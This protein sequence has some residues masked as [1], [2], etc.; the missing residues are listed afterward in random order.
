VVPIELIF[1]S[2]IIGQATGFFYL[3]ELDGRPQIA[4]VTNWHVLS[5][6][7]ADNPCLTLHKKGATPDS[8]RI[9]TI[10]KSSDLTRG[11]MTV[12]HYDFPMYEDD[13]RARWLQHPLK[14]D[15]DIALAFVNDNVSGAKIEPVNVVADA[16]DMKIEVGNDVYILGYPLGYR[17]FAHTPIWKRGTI[18]SEPNYDIEG[19]DAGKRVL[20]DATTRSAMSGS[21]V[22]MRQ[23]TH[24]LSAEGSIVQK[25]NATRFIGV[26]AQRP[27]LKGEGS[28]S[29]ELGYFFRSGHIDEIIKAVERGPNHGELP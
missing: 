23:K 15:I 22:I 12:L 1:R 16:Y 8:I 18:A 10:A 25:A 29:A 5:G 9:T 14:N 27:K 3:T 28:E 13:G 4:L 6:R 7:N 20:I 17:H 2:T 21:P 26:Y 24:Y 11:Q 19:S